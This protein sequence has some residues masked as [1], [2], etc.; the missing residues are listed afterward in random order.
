MSVSVLNT[1]SGAVDPHDLG[2]SESYEVPTFRAMW[3][4]VKG[5]G[6][7]MVLACDVERLPCGGGCGVQSAA[8]ER[9]F[10][11]A[12]LLASGANFLDILSQF[13]IVGSV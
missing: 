8:A 9:L 1:P 13:Q 6:A 5:L 4:D 2:W 7:V 3:Q 11:E 12:G 10:E